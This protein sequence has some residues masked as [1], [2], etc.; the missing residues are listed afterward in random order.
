M[1]GLRCLWLS[2]GS[3]PQ[4]AM[5]VEAMDA[6]MG[7][8]QVWGSTT[9]PS[10]RTLLAVLRCMH[11]ALMPGAPAPCMCR[12]LPCAG[13]TLSFLLPALSKLSYPPD[14]YPDDLKVQFPREHG[15]LP[16]AA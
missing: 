14:A 1:R 10:A 9:G 3:P 11:A 16:L 6:W 4:P 15:P 2:L 13:K 5:L 7:S 8:M 12:S